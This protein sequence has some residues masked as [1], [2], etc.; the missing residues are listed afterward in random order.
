MGHIYLVLEYVDHDL[1][2]LIDA[3]I[4]FAPAVTKGLIKQ[5]LDGLHYMHERKIVHRYGDAVSRGNQANP[6]G[7]GC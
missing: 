1:A 6:I 5:L 3:R 2:G 4:Q 7:P